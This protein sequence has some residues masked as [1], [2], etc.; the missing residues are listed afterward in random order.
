MDSNISITLTLFLSA[1]R[2]YAAEVNDER[3]N[4]FA[5]EINKKYLI[6]EFKDGVEKF[7][8]ISRAEDRDA[9]FTI[10]EQESVDENLAETSIYQ[11]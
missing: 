5:E 1:I 7:K 4:S 6:D 9:L 3:H 2:D 11:S 10:V 8:V